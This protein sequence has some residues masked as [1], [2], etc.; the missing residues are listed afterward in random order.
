MKMNRMPSPWKKIRSE[1]K[2]DNPWIRVTEDEV[3]NPA[4]K[5]GIYGVVHFKTYAVAIIPL[6]E[7]N[8]TWIVGQYRYPLDSYE[9]EVIEGGC[10]EGTPPVETAHREL[11]E[12]AGLLAE[13]M[14]LILEMQLSNS[15]T[16]EISY[17]YVARGIRIVNPEPDEDEKLTIKKLP[18]DDVYAMVMRGEIRDSL[19][20]ASVLKAKALMMEGK[21]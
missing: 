9:W 18:F 2:Y 1:I 12:E 13:R 5:P 20:V 7:E 15:T 10:P 11:H 21:L 16:D 6:D 19:S 4:G 14:E 17:T 8:N 3:I